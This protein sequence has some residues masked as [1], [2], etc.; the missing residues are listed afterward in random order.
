VATTNGPD[1]SGGQLAVEALMDDTCKAS[2]VAEPDDWVVGPDLRLTPPAGLTTY[3]GK[4]KLKA[5]GLNGGQSATE[6]DQQLVTD[7]FQLDVPLSAPF[8]PEGSGV[9]ID[10]S[11]RMPTAVNEAFVVTG[12]LPKTMAVKASYIVERRKRVE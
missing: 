10:S 9:V 3:A 11:R 4:C 1:L 2:A 7:R 5:L 8:L 6:G 12:P